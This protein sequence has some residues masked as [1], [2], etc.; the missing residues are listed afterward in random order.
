M[1]AWQRPAVV[2]R[3]AKDLDEVQ[4]LCQLTAEL[5][6]PEVHGCGLSVKQ[7]VQLEVRSGC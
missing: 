5:F 1:G 2:V 4:Q 3:P 7:Y 6:L